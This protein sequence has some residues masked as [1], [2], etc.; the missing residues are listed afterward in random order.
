[1]WP[2][3]TMR[4]LPLLRRLGCPA[5]PIVVVAASSATVAAPSP[6]TSRAAL[7][8]VVRDHGSLVGAV[9]AVAAPVAVVHLASG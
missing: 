4:L 7:E 9:V 3:T 5:R 6:V 2:K 8:A 1:M